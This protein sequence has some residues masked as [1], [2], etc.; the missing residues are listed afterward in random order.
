MLDARQL[1]NAFAVG[2][3]CGMTITR[4][5]TAALVGLVVLIAVVPLQIGLAGNA[6]VPTWSVFLVP[7]ILVTASR[8]WAGDW[9]LEREG[10]R[11]WLR[12]G[13]WLVVPIGLLTVAYISY[14]AY[15]IPDVG[16]Q[17]VGANL[18][19]PSLRSEEDAASWPI[20]GLPPT[21]SSSHHV[22][23]RRCDRAARPH[24][25]VLDEVIEQGWNPAQGEVVDWWKQNQAAIGLAR[26]TSVLPRGRFED[27]GRMTFFSKIDPSVA[28]ARTLAT[29]L[30]LDTR[31]RLSRG[32][33][34]G[35]WD[36]ILALFR[37]ANQLGTNSP[38]LMQM[39]IAASIHHQAV[40]LAFEWLGAPG[41]TP[42]TFR[43]AL[44]D[45][46]TLP[47]LPSLA[48]TMQV[49]ASIIERTLNLSGN[50]LADGCCT[51][52]SLRGIAPQSGASGSPGSW[53]LPGN[54]RG[55]AGSAVC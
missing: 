10:A 42:E 9:L 16:P 27:V 38:T 35:A 47:T 33:L 11:P 43:R 4:R 21:S 5:I 23:P 8:A 6:M 40:G 46:K 54:A 13:A 3:L 15:S 31:E 29:L 26:R 30:A 49:E 50:E 28:N 20:D 41:Q 52:S 14:R 22:S 51:R 45:L 32:D 7:L 24:S 12:L 2:L 36:D 39:M 34:P 25:D 55:L 37:I 17:F 48:A 44:A 19:G 53:R 1:A 18:Q